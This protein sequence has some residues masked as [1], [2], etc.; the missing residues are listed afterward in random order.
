MSLRCRRG[1]RS[2]L[3]RSRGPLK[4]AKGKSASDAAQAR[5]LANFVYTRF[6]NRETELTFP[7]PR[8]RV[9]AFQFMRGGP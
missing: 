4:L 9:S 6:E 1:L 7:R 5:P 8:L 3:R 2:G